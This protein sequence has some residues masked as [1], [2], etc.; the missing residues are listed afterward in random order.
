MPPDI[1]AL[2]GS[3]ARHLP[4]YYGMVKRLDEAFG[5]VLDALKSLGLEEDT[6][7][8]F[9]TDHGCHFKTRNGLIGFTSHRHV[10]DVLKERLLANMR[11]A[12]ES[13]SEIGNAA[14]QSSGQKKVNE[15]EAYE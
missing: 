13:K 14:E 11:E 4:G 9:T 1:R 15:E 6:I 5:R 2:G 10:A 8:V 3:S 12:G 7:V